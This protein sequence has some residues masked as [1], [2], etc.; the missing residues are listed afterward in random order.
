MTHDEVIGGEHLPY[1][2][3]M[4]MLLNPLWWI[5]PA[6]EPRW[7]RAELKRRARAILA[8]FKGAR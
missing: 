8:L 5:S 2:Y 1:P 6:T 3:R 7:H 4:W